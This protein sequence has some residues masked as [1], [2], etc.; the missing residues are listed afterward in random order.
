MLPPVRDEDSG[1]IF[2]PLAILVGTCVVCTAL[3]RHGFS[4]A[5]WLPADLL[6]GLCL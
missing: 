5:Y 3:T 6:L 2:L 1:V 4:R